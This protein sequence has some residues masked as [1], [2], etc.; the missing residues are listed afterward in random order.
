MIGV[1]C[2]KVGRGESSEFREEE[3]ARRTLKYRLNLTWGAGADK[4][5]I[6]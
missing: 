1:T 2:R 3:V 4:F 5:T 6:S